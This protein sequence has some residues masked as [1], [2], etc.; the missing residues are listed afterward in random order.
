MNS[1]KPQVS[2]DKPIGNGRKVLLGVLCLLGIFALC[3]FRYP[4]VGRDAMTEDLPRTLVWWSLAL[5]IFATTGLVALTRAP[6]DGLGGFALKWC[7]FYILGLLW[8]GLFLLAVNGVLDHR[9]HHLYPARVLSHHVVSSDYRGNQMYQYYLELADWQRPGGRV[10]IEVTAAVYDKI[11]NA[12]IMT[13]QVAQVETAPG[14]L[15]FERFIKVASVASVDV[16]KE[17]IDREDWSKIFS[18]P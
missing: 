3:G 5:S 6:G 18:Q 13:D 17:A 12:A 8:S 16:T 10:T 11:D 1:M 2:D 15:G 7:L 14:C 9:A 4:V